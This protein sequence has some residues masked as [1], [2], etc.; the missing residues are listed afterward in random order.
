MIEEDTGNYLYTRFET[1]TD[2]N[3]HIKYMVNNSTTDYSVED[4]TI[5][6][7]VWT[8]EKPRNHHN[9]V[10]VRRAYDVSEDGNGSVYTDFENVPEKAILAWYNDDLD[11]GIVYLWTKADKV[12]WPETTMNQMFYNFRALQHLDVRKMAVTPDLTNIRS[13]FSNCVSLKMLDLS[14]IDGTKLTVTA[15][16]FNG[17]RKLE[18]IYVSNDWGAATGLSNHTQMFEGCVNLVGGQ[19]TKYGDKYK[20]KTY[21]KVD[22]L[23]GQ[24][25]YLTF[26]NAI[27][28]SKYCKIIGADYNSNARGLISARDNSE[29]G[30]IAEIEGAVEVLITKLDI[31]NFGGAGVEQE[32]LFNDASTNRYLSEG[33]LFLEDL[34]LTEATVYSNPLFDVNN[35]YLEN[36]EFKDVTVKVI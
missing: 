28:G 9:G 6:Q 2:F 15:Q 19:G 3:R 10:G 5:Q 32:I 14:S 21:A 26:K 31:R 33:N 25:G 36:V 34:N 11:D 12:Y 27:I 20:D 7:I 30:G 13:A 24:L 18:K 16:A 4:V 23:N 1:S 22:G 8:D 29:K 35:L 17:C